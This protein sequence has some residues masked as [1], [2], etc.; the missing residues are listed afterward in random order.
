MAVLARNPLKRDVAVGRLLVKKDI[1]TLP[2]PYRHR[3]T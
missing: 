1:T 3:V 2:P